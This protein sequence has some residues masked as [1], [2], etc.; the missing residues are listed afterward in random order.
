MKF[1]NPSNPMNFKDNFKDNWNCAENL[2]SPIIFKEIFE[3]NEIDIEF[4]KKLEEYINFILDMRER[5]ALDTL[6]NMKYTILKDRIPSILENLADN[7]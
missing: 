3:R 2:E 6:R 5:K 1:S 4:E 7:N